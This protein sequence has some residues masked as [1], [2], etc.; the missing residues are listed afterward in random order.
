[1]TDLACDFQIAST[2]PAQ[3][4]PDILRA[5][6]HGLDD[7]QLVPG[8]FQCVAR[9]DGDSPVAADGVPDGV[10]LAR[11]FG[12]LGCSGE[13]D[14]SLS[15]GGPA[16]FATGCALCVARNIDWLRYGYTVFFYIYMGHSPENWSKM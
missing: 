5:D 9:G 7:V 14:D 3:L 1:M 12:H 2:F 16:D 13:S 4:R 11:E 6:P 10:V 15:V 8:G